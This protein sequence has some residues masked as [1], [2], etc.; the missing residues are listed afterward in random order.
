MTELEEALVALGRGL[1]FP[2]EPDFAARVRERLAERRRWWAPRRRALTLALAVLAVA[3]AAVLAV[4]PARTAILELLG[5]RGVTIERVGELPEVRPGGSLAFLGEEVDRDEAERRTPFP[6]RAPRL[7]G[8]GNPTFFVRSNPTEAVSLVYGDVERPR[9]VLTQFRARIEDDF[10]YK[11]VGPRTRV[12]RLTV[13]G[14]PAVWLAGE[15]HGFVFVTRGER[16][17]DDAFYLARN[18]LI[19]QSGEMTLRVEGDLTREQAS[20][21][22][23]ATS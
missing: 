6:I 18:T 22:A 1:E 13:R 12:E 4:P 14:E 15:P 2:A 17:A 11:A 20:T 8:L 23:R 16:I 7:D 19:W 5:L 9:L 10:V 3:V 21:I